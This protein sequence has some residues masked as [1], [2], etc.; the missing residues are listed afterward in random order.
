MAAKNVAISCH[1]VRKGGDRASSH[2]F[3][4]EKPTFVE[5]AVWAETT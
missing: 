1:L 2:S 4:P 5:I 3:H